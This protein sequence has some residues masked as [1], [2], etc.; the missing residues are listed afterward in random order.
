[1]TTLGTIA[2]SI[3]DRLAPLQG[4]GLVVRRQPNALRS[5]GVV[6]GNGV[7]TLTLESITG[8]AT[9]RDLAGVK[10]STTQVWL[11]NGKLRN[12][13]EQD[14]LENLYDWLM[15]QLF[16]WTPSG[17]SGPITLGTFTPQP[18]MED[19]WPVEMRLNV[20]SVLVGAADCESLLIDEVPEAE[21][22]SLLE[23]IFEAVEITDQWGVYSDTTEVNP[24]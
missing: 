22:A 8:V 24:C 2:Q 7:L 13:R 12:V 9:D 16:G 19:Y 10:Q 14:G 11:L 17:A 1:M 21:G 18:P 3:I 4:V 5:Q 6:T 15:E 20:P 23:A